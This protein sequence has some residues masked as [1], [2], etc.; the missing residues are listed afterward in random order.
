MTRSIRAVGLGFLVYVV[1]TFAVGQATPF[2]YSKI[3]TPSE[4][5]EL[6]VQLAVAIGVIPYLVSGYLAGRIAR[7]Q[8]LVFGLASATIG[9]ALIYIVWLPHEPLGSGAISGH[10]LF[11]LVACLAG[12][13]GELHASQYKRA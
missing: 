1:A 9:F 6:Y 4:L 12:G 2:L 7:A 5:S 11:L 3:E 13:V 8:G 10:A